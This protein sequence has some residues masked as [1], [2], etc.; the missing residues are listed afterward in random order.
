MKEL[1]YYVKL[2]KKT[3]TDLSNIVKDAFKV[4]AKPNIKTLVSEL[5]CKY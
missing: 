4:R 1:R 3:F 2:L 5:R